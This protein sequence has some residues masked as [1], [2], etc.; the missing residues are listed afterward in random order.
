MTVTI[1]TGA[2]AGLG[3]EFFKVLTEQGPKTDEIWLIARRKDRLE[4]LAATC[5]HQKVRVLPLDLTQWE[6]LARLEQILNTEKPEVK[7]LINN[8]GFGKMGYVYELSAADQGGMVDLNVRSLTEMSRMVIPFMQKG[9]F[10]L[11]VCSIASFVPNPRMTV[12]SSTKAYVLSF[13]KGLREELKPLGINVCALCPGPMRTEFLAV[14]GIGEGSSK[15]FDTLPYAKPAKVAKKALYWAG[16]GKAVYT[17]LVFFKFYRI[18]S[19]FLPH[20][21]LM[22]LSKV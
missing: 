4:Q 20:S 15:T 7:T 2:S 22:K 6:D 10:I 18:L 5:P 21:L 14:A 9:S 8:A 3:Q 17:P 1:L 16:K 11:N 13:S 12:Y 19:K